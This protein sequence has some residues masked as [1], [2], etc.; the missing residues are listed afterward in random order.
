MGL[1]RGQEL[2]APATYINLCLSKFELKSS[3]FLS[4]VF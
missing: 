2:L 3:L 1:T 4:T